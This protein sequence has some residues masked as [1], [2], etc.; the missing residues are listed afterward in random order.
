MAFYDWNHD[1]DNN[2]KDDFIEYQVFEDSERNSNYTPRRGGGISTFGAITATVGGLILAA[3]IIT[4][5]SGGESIPL[6]IIIVLWIV[7]GVALSILF[8]SIGL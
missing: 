8:D 3:L 5:I 7:C 4:L 1:G 6:F 2:F